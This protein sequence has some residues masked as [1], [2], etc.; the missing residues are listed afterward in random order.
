MHKGVTIQRAITHP[1]AFLG[2]TKVENLEDSDIVCLLSRKEGEHK[3]HKNTQK[4]KNTS[5]VQ[6]QPSKTKPQDSVTY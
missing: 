5:T 2:E 1:R 6:K 4:E 3:E